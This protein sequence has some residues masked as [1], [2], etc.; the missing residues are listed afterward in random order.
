MLYAAR[1]DFLLKWKEGGGERGRVMLQE[2][3]SAALAGFEDGGRGRQPKN[4][5]VS[6]SWRRQRLTLF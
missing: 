4:A 3:A 5:A 1:R 6:R 2:G